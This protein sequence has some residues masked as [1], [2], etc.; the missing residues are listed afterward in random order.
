MPTILDYY[1]YAK[2]ATAA[3]V[4]LSG[5]TGSEIAAAANGQE[6]IPLKLAEQMFVF[7]AEK[8][9]DPWTVRADGY[10]GN[11]PTGFAATLFERGSEKV[12]AIRGTEPT[13]DLG[14]DLLQADLAGIGIMGVAIS[15]AVE[16]VN[17]IRRLSTPAGQTVDRLQLH[18]SLTVPSVPSV[19]APGKL[20]GQSV[21]FYFTSDQVQGLG[22]IAAGEK[23]TVTGHS[24]GGHLAALAA[25]LFPSLV[26]DA[27]TYNAP[28]FDPSSVSVAGAIPNIGI[29]TETSLLSALAAGIDPQVLA[30]AGGSRQLTEKLVGLFNRYL[31]FGAAGSFAEVAARTHNLESENLEPGDD[32]SAVSGVFTNAQALP[33]ECLIPTERNSH[34]MN[35]RGQHDI[36]S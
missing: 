13:T 5:F 7:D 28:G 11:D 32:V 14:I 4:N 23:I 33:R 31:G 9:A 10:H 26:T 24:L 30:M 34:L 36:H 15:Q 18:A 22:L 21:Y 8:N 3:Y 16:M 27:Y 6:R 1:E 29:I 35:Q 17:Y 20:P 2:L 25:R 19:Q 12:L